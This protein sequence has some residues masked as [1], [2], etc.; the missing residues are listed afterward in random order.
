MPLE[1][2]I[3]SIDPS[4]LLFDE[5]SSNRAAVDKALIAMMNGASVATGEISFKADADPKVDALFDDVDDLVK[6]LQ[7]KGWK[8]KA[9]TSG[10]LVSD[11]T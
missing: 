11:R 2:R 4:Y 5:P 3:L 1:R 8:V 6:A 9:L 10:F 7:A